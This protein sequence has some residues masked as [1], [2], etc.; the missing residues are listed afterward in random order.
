MKPGIEDCLKRLS[1]EEIRILNIFDPDTDVEML[2]NYMQ[3][4][5][6]H[7][8]EMKIAAAAGDPVDLEMGQRIFGTFLKI[9]DDWE[10][11]SHEQQMFFCKAIRYFSCEDNEIPDLDE[12]GFED[13]MEVL[14]VALEFAGR[15]DLMLDPM[16][17]KAA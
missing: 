17:F 14:N 13:D 8:R 11:F 3:D 12:M 9:E 15:K 2:E 5:E 7:L 4:A 1:K 6:D 16:K 10:K